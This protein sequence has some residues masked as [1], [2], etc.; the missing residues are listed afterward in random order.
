MIVYHLCVE[1]VI[2][3]KNYDVHLDDCTFNNKKIIIAALEYN[4]I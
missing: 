4:I 3:I 1:N 2:F